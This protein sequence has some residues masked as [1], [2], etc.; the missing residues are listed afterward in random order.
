MSGG[1]VFYDLFLWLFSCVNGEH[2]CVKLSGKGQSSTLCTKAKQKCV[3]VIWAGGNAELS[4]RS[5][6]GSSGS[7]EIT[8]ALTEVIKVLKFLRRDM[9]TGFGEVVDAIDKEYLEEDWSEEDSKLELEVTPGKLTDLAVES[10]DG[11]WY[12]EWLVETGRVRKSDEEV[13]E[14]VEENMEKGKEVEVAAE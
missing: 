4:R 10:E 14:K 8:K 1:F 5:E 11:E 13:E 7:A 2:N 9:V 6:G 3:R 12:W